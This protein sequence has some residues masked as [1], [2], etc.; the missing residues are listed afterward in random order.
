MFLPK[1]VGKLTLAV[2]C[3]IPQALGHVMFMIPL[4]LSTQDFVTFRDAA[5][6][7]GLTEN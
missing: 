7:P 2:H 3:P 6:C 4:F 5:L 1:Q